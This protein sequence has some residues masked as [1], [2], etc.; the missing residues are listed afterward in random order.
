MAP[1]TNRAAA[2]PPAP[3]PAKRR[4]ERRG[5]GCG[6]LAPALLAA[7]LLIQPGGADPALCAGEKAM[8]RSQEGAAALLRGRYDQAIAAYDQALQES[9]LPPARQA[10]LYNDRGVAKWR[11]ARREEALADIDKAAELAPDQAMH[12]NN[13][14]AVLLDMGRARE[15]A[16]EFGR[17]IAL[18][19]GYGAAYNNRGAA[20]EELGRHEAAI[21][22]YRKAIALMPTHA[23]PFNGRGKAQSALNHPYAALRYLNRAMALNAR[24]PAASRNRALVYLQLERYRDAIADLDRILEQ[25]PDDAELYLLRGHAYARERRVQ[26]AFKDFARAIDLDANNAR[27][28]AERGQLY[29][30]REDYEPALANLNQAAALDPKIAMT[31]YN[32]GLVYFRLSDF[33]HAL[34][35]ANK[36]IELDPAYAAAYKLRGDVVE[37]QARR[38][39]RGQFQQ[40]AALRR[41]QAA[42]EA[43]QAIPEDAGAAAQDAAAPGAGGAPGT[44]APGRADAA[45]ADAVVQ[46]ENMKILDD[47]RKALELDP[48]LTEAR[49][50]IRKLTGAPPETPPSRLPP[51]AEAAKGWEAQPLAGGRYAAANS[52]YGK[53]RVPLEMHGPGL[54]EILEW[55]PLSQPLQGFG[56]LRY[57]AGDV[58]GADGKAAGR[59]EY[60]AIVD[61]Y[62]D[63]ILSIEPYVLGDAK[64]TWDWTRHR[65]TITDPEGVTSAFELR[66]EP[67]PAPVARSEG[68]PMGELFG[69]ERRSTRRS[70]GLFDWLFN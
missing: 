38:S 14:G 60:V 37:T 53:L 55:T 57:A 12:H 27:A 34:A 43:R 41:E 9:D 59:Y 3:A 70:P 48:L 17:A 18:A 54:P 44:A 42:R 13:R 32:R 24:Y 15:A 61:Y 6:P 45:R 50:A 69:S 20:N 66:K 25:A 1:S 11:M 19:P 65:V 22:D 8:L 2:R 46:P 67:P 68:D 49:D 7:V 23:A 56:L 62:R 36:A 28:Y 31:F 35:D 52:R 51:A 39:F 30:E 40:E 16:D 26:L 58:I 63:A 21:E 4:F 47:Y 10:D 5:S 64:A 29:V 33:D